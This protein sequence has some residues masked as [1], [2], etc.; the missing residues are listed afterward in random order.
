MRGSLPLAT[1]AVGA[2]FWALSIVFHSRLPGPEHVLPSEGL[3]TSVTFSALSALPQRLRRGRAGNSTDGGSRPSAEE[4]PEAKDRRRWH[5]VAGSRAFAAP[6]C[7]PQPAP[8]YPVEFP[9]LNVTSNWNPDTPDV[10]PRHFAGL[11][12]FDF[13][14]QRDQ[15]ESY[16]QAE[17]PFIVQGVP[18][19]DAAVDKWRDDKYLEKSLG[20]KAYLTEYSENNH[21]MYFQSGGNKPPGWEPPVEN[22]RM[23]F[24]KWNRIAQQAEAANLSDTEAHYY[25]R[26]NSYEAPFLRRDLAALTPHAEQ[27]FFIVDS[28][29]AKGIHCRF[30]MRGIVAAA[31]YDGSRNFVT[32]L[33]GFRRYLLGAPRNCKH[34][35]LYHHPHPSARHSEVDWSAPDLAKFPDFAQARVNE[36]I[37]TPGDLLYIPSRWI[38]FIM[39]V[40][41]NLQCNAR[42][43]KSTSG[44]AHSHAQ[45]IDACMSDHGAK[46]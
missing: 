2:G 27:G 23:T 20:S 44:R 21:F 6:D 24:S 41:T 33:R 29:Q 11:C 15:A 3:P 25:F 42:S 4:S 37:L 39:S 35:H 16:R 32:I 43:G 36:V 18:S 22:Q 5:A 30:G 28:T 10:P 14:S 34:M 26:V 1:V 38:H 7:P 13:Q 12:R 40:N 31:H 45:V 8:D 17:V 9:I 19:V 46:Y